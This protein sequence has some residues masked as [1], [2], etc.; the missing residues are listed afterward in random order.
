MNGT[1]VPVDTTST[2]SLSALG[3]ARLKMYNPDSKIVLIAVALGIAI[4]LIGYFFAG[5]KKNKTAVGFAISVSTVVG[6]LTLPLIFQL[7]ESLNLMGRPPAVT[8]LIILDFVFIACVS[9]LA[10]EIVTVTARE[11]RPPE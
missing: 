3:I 1:S 9:A 10:Y 7:G 11:A 5:G 2:D 6:I 4:I 8:V